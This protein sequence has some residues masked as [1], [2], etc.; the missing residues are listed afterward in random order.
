M[1]DKKE[2][3]M[4]QL[5]LFGVIVFLTSCA[6][7]FHT[8]QEA[9]PLPKGSVEGSAAYGINKLDVGVR[10]GLHD[11]LDGGLYFNLNTVD[12]SIPLISTDVKIRLT[13]TLLNHFII[14]SGAGFGTGVEYRYSWNETAPHESSEDNCPRGVFRMIPRAQ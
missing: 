9:A 10:Y 4:K 3:E 11:R 7:S 14:S 6:T 13:D 2:M 12:M 1:R 5:V 8:G